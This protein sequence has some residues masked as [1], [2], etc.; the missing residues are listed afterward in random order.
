MNDRT[1]QLM[2]NPDIK[3][4]MLEDFYVSPIEFDPGQS[5]LQLAKGDTGQVGDVTV[6]FVKFD[7]DAESNAAMASPVADKPVTVGANLE[8]TRGGKTAALRPTYQLNATTGETMSQPAT[9]PGGGTITVV[10]I[11]ATSGA[12]QLETAGIS[13]PPR[14]SVDVTHKPLIQMVWGGLYIVLIGGLMATVQRL[15]DARLR[16]KLAEPPIKA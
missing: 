10:G 15:R 13:V 6:R 2:V 3:S 1:R 5:T 9:L 4:S 14:L 12:V 7:L 16:D 8:I 11:D